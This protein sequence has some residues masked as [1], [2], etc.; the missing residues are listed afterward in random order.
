MNEMYELTVDA[1]IENLDEV[2]SFIE[3]HLEEWDCAMKI[4]TQINIAAEEIFVNIAHYAYK[5]HDGKAK[6]TITRKDNA[7]EITFSDNGTPYN[8]LEHEDPD[9]TLSAEEREIGGLGIYIVKKS[10]DS[11]SYEY[12]DNHNILVFSKN[13]E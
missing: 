13:I 8:P 10:M 9:V 5:N 3:Q 1:K 11:V 7:A 4:M 6:I 12:R 2:T